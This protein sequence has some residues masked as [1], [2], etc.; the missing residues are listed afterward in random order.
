MNLAE[1]TLTRWCLSN[2]Q[3]DSEAAKISVQDSPL[4]S[5]AAVASV[6]PLFTS[7][8]VPEAIQTAFQVGDTGFAAPLSRTL[9]GALQ[10]VSLLVAVTSMCMSR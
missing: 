8:N 9:Q 3:S 10:Q 4:V 6:L 7:N 1:G 5:Q 2:L